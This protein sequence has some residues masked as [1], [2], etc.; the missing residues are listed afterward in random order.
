MRAARSSVV[1]AVAIAVALGGW[2]EGERD[3][4]EGW[5][6]VGDRRRHGGERDRGATK[7]AALSSVRAL[8]T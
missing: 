8:T 2:R 3:T 5:G 4:G 1:I 7:M 6:D